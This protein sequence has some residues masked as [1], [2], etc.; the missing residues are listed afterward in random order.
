MLSVARGNRARQKMSF[1]E[2]LGEGTGP[3]LPQLSFLGPTCPK[4][5]GSGTH[6]GVPQT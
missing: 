5:P 3:L 2:R 4:E 1:R 6:N